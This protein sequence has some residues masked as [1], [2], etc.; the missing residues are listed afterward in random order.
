MCKFSVLE[1]AHDDKK[2]QSAQVV[3]IRRDAQSAQEIVTLCASP[4]GVQASAQEIMVVCNSGK[5]PSFLQMFL[6]VLIRISRILVS[7]ELP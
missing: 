3:H 4:S 6:A 7:C 5:L 2:K 1:G